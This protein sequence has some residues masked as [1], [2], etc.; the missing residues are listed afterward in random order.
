MSLVKDAY[1]PPPEHTLCILVAVGAIIT[2][3]ELVLLHVFNEVGA[4]RRLAAQAVPNL[5]SA[6]P[7]AH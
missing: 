4:L 5:F 3:Q 7:T 6:R 2:T 1:H